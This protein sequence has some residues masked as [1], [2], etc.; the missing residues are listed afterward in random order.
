MLRYRVFWLTSSQVNWK[1][2]KS[3]LQ[4]GHVA[5]FQKYE[6]PFFL[7][8]QGL[9]NTNNSFIKELNKHQSS[10]KEH[11]LNLY[12]TP[13]GITWFLQSVGGVTMQRT[14]NPCHFQ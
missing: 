7:D 11:F 3:P 6:S 13:T 4:F 1:L 8:K 2:R 14:I 12:S 9:M 5:I 10:D